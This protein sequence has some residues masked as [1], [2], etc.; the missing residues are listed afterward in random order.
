M[1]VA[2]QLFHYASEPSETYKNWVK[3]TIGEMHYRLKDKTKFTHAIEGLQGMIF[4]ETDADVIAIH[5]QTSI[6]SPNGTN[7]LVLE[8]KQQLKIRAASAAEID[9]T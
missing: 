2:R 4:Y 5:A 7:H 8:Y 6:S 3:K 1:I 9:L